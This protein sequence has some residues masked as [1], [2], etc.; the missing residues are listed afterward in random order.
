[1]KTFFKTTLL[2][3]ALTLPAMFSNA[4]QISLAVDSM[5]GFPNLAVVSPQTY[6]FTLTVRS[7]SNSAFNGTLK[8]M[9]R[10]TTT[11]GLSDT[12]SF[13]VASP[14]V[15]ISP[16]GTI[17]MTVDSFKFDTAASPFR[18]GGNVVVVWPVATNGTAV[19]VV[20][21][22]KTYVYVS[23]MAGFS[24]QHSAKKNTHIFPIPANDKLFFGEK[25]IEKSLEY[26]RITDIIG[27]QRYY[28]EIPA[29]SVN[30]LFLEE[31]IYFIEIKEKDGL[32]DISKFI[33]SR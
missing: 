2:F 28:S 21:T 15:T 19:F 29:S 9:Y 7:F 3:C 8:I 17:V 33:I 22:F 23:A 4:Q 27:R 13:P 6:N 32:P 20:D 5:T 1:M 14:Q 24:D 25:L 26:V 31:G 11:G 10:S 12:A 16:M 30:I 18:L